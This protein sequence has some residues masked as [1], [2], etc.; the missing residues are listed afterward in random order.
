V[1]SG[2]HGASA[3]ATTRSLLWRPNLG[4]GA[5]QNL[6][7]NAKVLISKQKLSVLALTIVVPAGFVTHLEASSWVPSP[8]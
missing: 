6:E 7:S 3:I 1:D 4:I 2:V 8:R 5:V